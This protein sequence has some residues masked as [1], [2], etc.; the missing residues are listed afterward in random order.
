MKYIGHNHYTQGGYGFP[1]HRLTSANGATKLAT[2]GTG[3]TDA[4]GLVGT[5][6]TGLV[7]YVMSEL[8]YEHLY[9]S[10]SGYPMHKGDKAGSTECIWSGSSLNWSQAEEVI[11]SGDII[12]ATGG[13]MGH[14]M[15]CTQGKDSGQVM[16]CAMNQPN[17]NQVAGHCQNDSSEKSAS[18]YFGWLNN[19]YS[20]VTVRLFRLME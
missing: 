13:G 6:C 19:H 1:G 11:Q 20:G 7:M 16:Q 5:D 14:A 18:G 10:T 15:I 17:C 3:F 2:T 8:G 4:Y 12:V 9:W